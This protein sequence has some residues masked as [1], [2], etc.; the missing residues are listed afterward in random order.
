M[1][2]LLALDQ[3]ILS[4]ARTLSDAAAIHA[5]SLKWSDIADDVN[6]HEL[7]AISTYIIMLCYVCV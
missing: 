6:I 3:L 4:S 1:E 2:Q 5:S 7:S